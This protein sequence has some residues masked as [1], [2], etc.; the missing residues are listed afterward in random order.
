[1]TPATPTRSLTTMDV[2]SSVEALPEPYARALR[3][4]LAGAS[5]SELAASVAV[6]PEAAHNLLRLAVAKLATL[7]SSD[8]EVGALP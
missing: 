2:R 8:T 1:M 7:L 5:E 4:A 3:A 6:P